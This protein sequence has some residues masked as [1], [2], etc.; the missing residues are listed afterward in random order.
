MIEYVYSSY[1][2]FGLVEIEEIS[3]MGTPRATYKH[4]KLIKPIHR[5]IMVILGILL[6]ALGYLM[7]LKSIL[8]VGSILAVLGF[9][10]A[11]CGVV[12]SHEL[13]TTTE[14]YDGDSSDLTRH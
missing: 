7:I 8:W 5:T 6:V 13:T 4:V 12:A 11:F 3:T 14:Q 9:F 10:I 2:H 1:Q